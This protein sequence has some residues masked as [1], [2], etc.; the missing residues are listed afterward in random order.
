MPR[1]R[2][3]ISIAVSACLTATSVPVMAAPPVK[4]RPLVMPV[5]PDL[6][7]LIPV[8]SWGGDRDSPSYGGDSRYGSDRD[9]Q[10]AGITAAG[11]QKIEWLIAD[12]IRHCEAYRP[13]WRVDCLADGFE[14][15][16]RT[17]PR[18]EG[19]S[20]LRDE[21]SSTADQ[22]ALVARRNADPQ[23]QPSRLRVQTSAGPR[24]TSRPIVAIDPRLLPTANAT[25]DSIVSD[26][27]TTLLR[28]AR[29][30]TDLVRIAAAVD[31][32]RVLLRSS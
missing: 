30:E 23:K 4:L 11:V 8:Q 1:V 26:L 22:L 18:G 21:L 10:P 24:R 6:L 13:I 25:A 7:P 31:S 12:R 2:I 3:A 17:L 14:Q 27:S 9:D 16:A 29:N 32:T 19:Y 15:I 5:T 28:S 20:R